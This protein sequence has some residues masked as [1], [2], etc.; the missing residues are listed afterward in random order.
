MVLA[1]NLAQ[2]LAVLEE[3]RKTR[4]ETLMLLSRAPA[5]LRA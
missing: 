5:R 1:S 2:Q 4:Q 3:R